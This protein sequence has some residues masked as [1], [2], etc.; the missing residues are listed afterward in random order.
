MRLSKH[1][2]WIAVIFFLF[3]IPLFYLLFRWTYIPNKTWNDNSIS[4]KCIVVGNKIVGVICITKNKFGHKAEEQIRCFNGMATIRY[5]NTSKDFQV[6]YGSY[7]EV[8]QTLENKYQKGMCVDC[9]VQITNSSDFELHPK[10]TI[11]PLV[12]SILVPGTILIILIIW[13]TCVICAKRKSYF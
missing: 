1:F 8:N 3:V 7:K 12:S 13:G 4:A 9:V 11:F 5:V 10:S 6:A 2:I